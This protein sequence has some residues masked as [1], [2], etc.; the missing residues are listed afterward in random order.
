MNSH[1]HSNGLS[2]ETTRKINTV[3]AVH[4]EIER[5]ILYGSRAK[6]NS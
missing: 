2:E 5:V 1:Q 3:F 4:P 6:G